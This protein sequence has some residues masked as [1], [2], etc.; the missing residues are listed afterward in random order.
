MICSYLRYCALLLI[1]PHYTQ[2]NQ[3]NEE[4][5]TSKPSNFIRSAPNKIGIAYFF[6]IWPKQ[7]IKLNY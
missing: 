1:I 2:E 5:T 4:E 7:I 3:R 6:Y